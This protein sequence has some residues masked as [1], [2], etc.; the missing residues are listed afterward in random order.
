MANSRSN[1]KYVYRLALAFF[2]EKVQD[3]KRAATNTTD[4]LR[5]MLSHL[6]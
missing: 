5:L 1:P 3:V 6:R 4:M 2:Y